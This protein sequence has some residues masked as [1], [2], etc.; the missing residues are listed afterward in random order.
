MLVLEPRH[1]RVLYASVS[2]SQVGLDR[3][4][5]AVDGL[6]NNF[7]YFRNRS[8]QGKQIGFPDLPL[9]FNIDKYIQ[10]TIV[11]QGAREDEIPNRVLDNIINSYI[12]E[13]QDVDNHL[14]YL[15]LFAYDY[16]C[17]DNY[18]SENWET[19][20]SHTDDNITALFSKTMKDMQERDNLFDIP[21]I[22]ARLYHSIEY[23]IIVEVVNYDDCLQS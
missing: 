18:F 12:N 6:A 10:N 14:V 15:R 2:N 13:V 21:D 22:G 9:I 7:R 19:F 3:S 17:L 23:N 11:L 1:D 4:L 20:E 8:I 16:K 5:V